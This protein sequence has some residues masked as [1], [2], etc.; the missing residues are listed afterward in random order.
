MTPEM[1]QLNDDTSIRY[2]DASDIVRREW[3]GRTTQAR[4]I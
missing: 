4:G 2:A 1:A 3:P